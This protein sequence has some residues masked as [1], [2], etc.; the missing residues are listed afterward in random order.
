MTLQEILKAKG[1]DDKAVESVIGE[2]KQNKIF[3]SA[4]ENLDIRYGK[5]KTDFDAL[6]KQH[7]ESTALIEQMK[8]DNAGNEALQSK[9]T[10]YEQKIQQMTTE[11]QQTK[12]DAAL[13]V[14]LLEAKVTDV[15]YLTFKIKEKGEVKLGDDGKIKGIDDTIAALKTQYPQ[16][17]ASETKK[18]ID[19]NKLPSGD[20]E[21]KISQDAFNK[22]GYQDRLKVFNENPELY[23][24]LS[25]NKTN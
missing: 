14:A 13:K 10:E 2:M 16:H 3:T 11:L 24:E 4:E 7:G 18:K 19:E 15:D 5:L 6:T 12:L 8:K 21:N 25:G 20:D 9:I 23:N 17:F 1:L 22:M